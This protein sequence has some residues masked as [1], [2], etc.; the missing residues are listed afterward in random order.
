MRECHVDVAIPFH[1]R[2]RFDEASFRAE[3]PF[4]FFRTLIPL[5]DRP[6]SGAR[7]R[8]TNMGS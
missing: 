2:P 8:D 5:P 7:P 1:S 3:N 4:G 6:R